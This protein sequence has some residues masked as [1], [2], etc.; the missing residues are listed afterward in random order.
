M[1]HHDNEA[2]HAA[3]DTQVHTTPQEGHPAG[4]DERSDREIGGPA[5]ERDE[6]RD[7]S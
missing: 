3:D 2:E 5:P 1:S 4:D 6:P 7:E